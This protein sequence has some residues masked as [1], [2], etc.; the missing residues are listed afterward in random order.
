M[1][2]V[3]RPSQGTGTLSPSGDMVNYRAADRVERISMATQQ[4]WVDRVISGIK[5]LAAI[6]FTSRGWWTLGNPANLSRD[7]SFDYRI[8]VGD[9]RNN[10]IIMACIELASTTFAQSP[11]QLMQKIDDSDQIVP[12]HEMIALIKKPNLYYSGKL[13]WL[14][15]IADWMFGNAYWLKARSGAGKVVGLYWV[16]STM[17]RPRWDE[18]DP[19]SYITHYDYTP[20]GTP[21]EMAPEDVVH[22]RNGIDPKNVRLGLSKLGALLREISTD[23]EAAEYSNAILRN[24]GVAGMIISPANEK[25][26]LSPDDALKVKGS[27]MARTSGDRRGE[28]L[29][30]GG[31]VKVDITSPDPT[32][33]NLA[34]LRHVPEERITAM[35]GTPAVVVGL[36]S[37]LAH[38]TYNN[39]DEA[40][41]IY[42]ENKVIPMQQ[43]IAEDLQVQLLPDWEVKPDK[44]T[45]EFN[46]D[47]VRVLKEDETA[48]VARLATELEHGTITV[49]EARQ[50][51]GRKAHPDDF[52]ALASKVKIV[53]VDAVL[54]PPQPTYVDN[55]T[56]KPVP[57][58]P[59]TGKPVQ[60]APD[61]N[62]TGA[63]ATGNTPPGK[64]QKDIG[65]SI[66]RVRARMKAQCTREVAG[67]LDEQKSYVLD[68]VDTS[69][70]A[71]FRINWPRLTEDTDKLKSVLEPWYKRTLTAI[72]DLVQD[73]LGTRYEMSGS[74][75]RTYLKSAAINIK[76]INEETR[77]AVAAAVK[78]SLA[79]DE[80]TEELK[81]RIEGLGV[82]S[83]DRASLI[84]ETELASASNLAQ[85]ESYKSSD[86]VVGVLISDGDGDVVCAAMDGMKV[87]IAEARSIPPLGHPRCVRRFTHITDTAD[88]ESAA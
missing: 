42:Y 62:A 87:A 4:S 13:L 81:A 85:I 44:Y 34:E 61:P 3:L 28:P 54:A 74:D 40:R 8:R 27:I 26:K 51:R 65:D 76:G 36:G 66:V 7:G 56:G 52:F 67:Y 50:L 58:D 59:V 14:A 29:V 35:F 37:G 73:V 33:M 78:Q 60:N 88:L 57:I 41:K 63:A 6:T 72:H 80:S 77:S 24:Q 1:G 71:A 75:E 64:Q 11:A 9:G 2:M 69:A 84:A 30:L 20:N 38:S 21:V 49:N 83:S 15:T 86:V 45:I 5:S 19:T 68:Q 48:L 47:N 18:S 25:V 46:N 53:A 43:L 23:D 31:S 12:D 55:A 16:P 10:A 39:V 79:L 17:M 70:K 22:F 82:F 32:K